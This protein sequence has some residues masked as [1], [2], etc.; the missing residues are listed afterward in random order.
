MKQ[1]LTTIIA[2]ISLA[3][4]APSQQ[5]PDQKVLVLKDKD[6]VAILGYDA[7]AYFTDHKPVKGNP[8]YQAEYGGVK[9]YFS[10]K[11]HKVLFDAKPV[12]YAPAYGGYCG[13][14]ASIGKVRPSDPLIWSIV[15][16]QLIVQHTKGADDLWKKDVK[17]N[18][19]KA[20]KYWPHLI[21]A[22]SGKKNPV[23]GLFGGSVLDLQKIK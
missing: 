9:Y 16:R 5:K 14:A 20:D 23:D 3:G 13:Y 4:V 1:F 19:S 10:T 11:K 12:K 8:K 6:G 21:A 17:G 18:K 7:V 22:K 15:D 2:I